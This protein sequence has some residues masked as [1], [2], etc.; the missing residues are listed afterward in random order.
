VE[1]AV[2]QVAAVVAVPVEVDLVVKDLMDLQLLQIQT[3]VTTKLTIQVTD[4]HQSFKEV[5]M[6]PHF[7]AAALFG[8]VLAIIGFAALYFERRSAKQNKI[9]L[10]GLKIERMEHFFKKNQ[11]KNLEDALLEAIEAY[12]DMQLYE[13]LEAHYH[14][15]KEEVQLKNRANRV[16]SGKSELT[17]EIMSVQH[18]P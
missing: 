14:K 18:L 16:S 6:S 9:L 5:K 11:N 12:P 8:V 13:A 2:L 1:E 10:R 7:Y 17:E 3:P 4:Q 15:V